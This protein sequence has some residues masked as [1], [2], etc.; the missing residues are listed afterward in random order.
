MRSPSRRGTG[1]RRS[2]DNMGPDRTPPAGYGGIKQL[3]NIQ[4]DLTLRE[5]IE[6]P[7]DIDAN[8]KIVSF[9]DYCLTTVPRRIIDAGITRSNGRTPAW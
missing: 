9:R 4:E 6:K 5:G 3:V 8:R 2:Y 1:T 7:T